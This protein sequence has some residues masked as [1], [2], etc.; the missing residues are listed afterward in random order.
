MEVEMTSLIDRIKGTL[1]GASH[2]ETHDHESNHAHGHPE[3]TPAA[4]APATDEH[5]AG[6]EHDKKGHKHC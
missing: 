1:Q 5:P 2:H 6:H 3:E 4:P